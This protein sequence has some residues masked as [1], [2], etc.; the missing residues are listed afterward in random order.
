[1]KSITILSSVVVAVSAQSLRGEWADGV[2]EVGEQI[3]FFPNEEYVVARSGGI[4]RRILLEGVLDENDTTTDEEEEMM[5]TRMMEE[6]FVEDG[7]GEFVDV[8]DHDYEFEPT[9]A[10]D[11][12]EMAEVD[13][14]DYADVDIVGNLIED[15]DEHEFY[16][17]EDDEPINKD[18]SAP[19]P[20]TVT[21][22]CSMWTYNITLANYY[23]APT[24]CL[25]YMIILPNPLFFFNY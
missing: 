10:A 25:T 20:G 6:Y 14:S 24:R 16:W 21:V 17:D 23:F 12:M 8:V 18:G 3:E 22:S 4:D 13:N 15:D 1:M 2:E 5:A 11:E 19:E 9:A 7:D